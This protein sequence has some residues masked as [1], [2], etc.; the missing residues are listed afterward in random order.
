MNQE[1]L[2]SLEDV[3]PQEDFE[4]LQQHGLEIMYNRVPQAKAD[5]AKIVEEENSHV[6]R[7][8][9]PSPVSPR[10]ADIVDYFANWMLIL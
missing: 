4:I 8:V 1:V 7:T 6:P 5:S 3:C 10:V 9:Q 2:Q